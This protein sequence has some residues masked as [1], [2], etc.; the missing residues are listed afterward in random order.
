MFSYIFE[1]GRLD[2]IAYIDKGKNMKIK[3]PF[4]SYIINLLLREVDKKY[5]NQVQRT[6]YS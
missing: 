5:V 2:N 1:I 3:L 6:N 4:T